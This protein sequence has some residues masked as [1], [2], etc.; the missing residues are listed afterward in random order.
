WIRRSKVMTGSEWILTRFGSDR[1]GKA[2]HII[3]AIFAIISTIGFIAYFFE[4]IGKFVTIILPWDLTLHYGD[5]ILLTSER[6]YALIIILLT[7]I[8]TVKGGMFSVV[9]T[10]VVQY[11][12]MIV[13]GVLIAGYAFINYSDL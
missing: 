10:E 8:Y 11:L 6:S 12:I 2:S 3:V 1:A 9:A 13:A 5:L 7:T 4:G